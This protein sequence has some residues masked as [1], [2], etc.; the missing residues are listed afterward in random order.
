MAYPENGHTHGPLDAVGGQA[1]TKCSNCVFHTANQLCEVYQEFLDGANFEP[2]TFRKRVWKHD[3]SAD[4]R[5]WIE[6]IPV[7]F[8][9]LTGPQAPHGFRILF[10]KQLEG[11]DDVQRTS[12]PDAAPAHPDDL[13]MAV[14]GFMSDEKPFQ[15]SLLVPAREVDDLRR[16]FSLQPSG[17]HGRRHFSFADREEMVRK[18]QVCFDKGGIN[19]EART[20]LCSRARDFAP[21][22]TAI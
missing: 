12:W 7:S 21:R 10:R 13:V 3:Q 6:E 8:G 9:C 15:I 4:W 11:V 22:A 18:T 19:E 17:S 5:E 20:F 16:S 1:V 2:G 14:H